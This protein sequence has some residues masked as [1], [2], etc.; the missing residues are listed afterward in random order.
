MAL[1]ATVVFAE[2]IWEFIHHYHY[3]EALKEWIN[4]GKSVE[5]F[6]ENY[7]NA[8]ILAIATIGRYLQYLLIIWLSLLLY[9]LKQIKIWNPIVMTIFGLMGFV[10][11]T[12]IYV[13]QFNIPKGFEILLFFFIPGFTFLLLYWLGVALLTKFKKNEIGD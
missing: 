13:T 12:V 5:E 1:I 9:K 7:D 10:S 2:F 4:Q 6:T 8:T 11:A 3:P